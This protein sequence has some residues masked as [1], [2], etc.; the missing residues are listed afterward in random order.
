[1]KKKNICILSIH[2][3]P[4]LS[5]CSALIEDLSQ[6]L[7]K[8]NNIYIITP[9]NN[10]NDSYR[11]SKDGNINLIKFKAGNI[12]TN[13][14]IFRFFI[15][16]SLPF[17]ARRRLQD[18][19]KKQ[20]FDLIICYSPSIF[21]YFLIKKIKRQAKV[22]LVLRDIFPQ[23]LIDT[24]VINKYSP[25]AIYSKYIENKLYN[26]SDK[27]GVQSKNNQLHFFHYKKKIYDK[28]EVLYNWSNQYL[29]KK[30]NIRKKYLEISKK[31]KSKT[32]F[33]FGGVMDVAQDMPNIVRL[34]KSIYKLKNSFFLFMGSGK[35]I[36]YLNK[37]FKNNK[38]K[39]FCILEN[40]PTNEYYFLLSHSDIGLVS[41]ERKLK[42]HNFP[43]KILSYMSE[44]L[45]ILGSINKNND[46]KEI[47][48]LNNC[49]LIS[50][51]YDDQLFKKNALMLFNNSDLRKKMS[52]NSKKTLFKYFDTKKAADQIL[53]ILS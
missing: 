50:E 4:I 35:K 45:P 12:K 28:T 23:W 6:E 44:S 40:V 11:I 7:S 49:G 43:G 20:Y 19:L 15:E 51:N 22:Y 31:L 34:I 27:V 8:K 10:I 2:Y 21:W 46:L 36:N 26:I 33:V 52:H 39:N 32:V 17:I 5:S 1:M 9:S 3:K 48:E 42:T 53:K 18:L 14:N 25:V 37:E 29:I 41:L 13:N 30:Q 38:I 47:I 24:G 16:L